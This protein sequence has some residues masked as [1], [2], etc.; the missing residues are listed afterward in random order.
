MPASRKKFTSSQGNSSTHRTTETLIFL[1]QGS[2]SPEAE[3]AA[4]V[5]ADFVWK[6]VPAT[7]LRYR[8]QQI[9]PKARDRV[10]IGAVEVVSEKLWRDDL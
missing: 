8:H 7:K 4:A 6:S 5:G 2:R 9:F 1:T 3:G 10:S